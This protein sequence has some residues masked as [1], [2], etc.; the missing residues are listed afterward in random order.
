MPDYGDSSWLNQLITLDSVSGIMNVGYDRFAIRRELALL[1]LLG[2]P[3]CDAACGEWPNPRQSSHNGAFSPA[4]AALKR[5]PVLRWAFEPQEGSISWSY[6][7]VGDVDGDGF[8]EIV[9]GS[10]PLYE[11][12]QQYALVY[13]LEHDGSLKWSSRIDGYVKWA[14]PVLVDVDGDGLRDV[15]IGGSW[16]S[17]LYALR[18]LDGDTLW[19]ALDG[20][21]QVGMNAG[22]LDGDGLPEIVV[23]DYQ[24]PRMV[25]S[26]GIHGH[27]GWEFQTSGTTYNIPAI[28][29]LGTHR[30]VLFTAHAP[31]VRERL[32]FVDPDGDEIWH[33]T[34]SPSDEQLELIPDELGYLPDFGYVSAAI[35]DFDGDGVTEVGFGT[36]MN[37]YV[38]EES[39]VL[40]WKE[41]TGILGNGFTALLNVHGDTVSFRDH[42]Y[43]IYDALVADLDQDGAA[44]VVHNV[45]SDWWGHMLEGDP[46]SLEVTEVVYRSGLRARSGI[47]GRLLWEFEAPHVSLDV[48]GRG[49][50]RE[51]VGCRCANGTLVIVGANDGYLYALDGLTG[52]LVWEL[53][54]E[55]AGWFRGMAL[56]DLDGDGMDELIVSH[57]GKIE[58]WSE[59]GSP[60]LRAVLGQASIELSWSQVD[61]AV[62]SWF[63]YRDQTPFFVPNGSNLLGVLPGTQSHYSDPA[64]GLLGVEGVNAFYRLVGQAQGGQTSAPTNPVGEW[65]REFVVGGKVE[66]TEFR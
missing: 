62:S 58:A 37:Y 46:S 52:D 2:F 24:N 20:L 1:I 34:A 38:L 11:G 43:Q 16:W 10:G 51:P 48:F 22:D 27:V 26:V 65:D 31:G 32:Y 28:G 12:D 25:R 41:P 18:G 47:D 30:G 5:T 39:G 17:S 55:G 53:W 8:P 57:G 50:T 44:D 15:V 64:S 42:H 63:L 6:I 54:G 23:A 19:V 35:A 3:A 59:I 13:L 9:G 21:A 33:Y 40:S 61:P 7:A 60:V 36:D 29:V 66:V 14:S 4:H 45:I 49:E 56:G